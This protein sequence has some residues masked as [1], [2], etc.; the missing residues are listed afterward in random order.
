MVMGGGVTKSVFKTA[1]AQEVS[2]VAYEKIR[3]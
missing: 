2:E 3:R 1:A